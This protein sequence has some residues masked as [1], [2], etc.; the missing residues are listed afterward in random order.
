MV[1]CE[2]APPKQRPDCCRQLLSRRLTRNQFS[3]DRKLQSAVDH[4]AEPE[5]QTDG[6]L[7]SNGQEPGL[8]QQRHAPIRVRYCY[9][10]RRLGGQAVV[11]EPGEVDVD[12]G[13]TDDGGDWLRR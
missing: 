4:A 6:P 5:Q 2:R 1:F 12:S 9:T 7:R 13:T 8:R 11:P 10:D 3:M